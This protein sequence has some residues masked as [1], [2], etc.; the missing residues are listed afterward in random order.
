MKFEELIK[1]AKLSPVHDKVRKLKKYRLYY[2]LKNK[3]ILRWCIIRRR[4]REWVKIK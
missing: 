4:I 2:K 1:D 3:I